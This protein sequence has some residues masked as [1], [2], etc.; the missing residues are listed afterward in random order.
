MKTLKEL[1]AVFIGNDQLPIFS[2]EN[3]ICT[4]SWRP[5]VKVAS[6]YDNSKIFYLVNNNIPYDFL[7]AD[8]MSSFE[9]AIN[10]KIKIKSMLNTFE[11]CSK[12]EI[13]KIQ[14]FDISDVKSLH[15]L[16]YNNR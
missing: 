10:N 1:G 6:Q 8:N 11:N 15:K 16:F 7:N 12:L 4:Y 2:Y 3:D 14:G 5:D 9:K 13:F